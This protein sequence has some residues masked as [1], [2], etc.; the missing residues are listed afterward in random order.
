[1]FVILREADREKA[2]RYLLREPEM[3]LFF[4]GDLENHGFD[5]EDVTLH[6]VLKP[7]GS[8][9]ALA[10]RYQESWLV[11]SDHEDFD[12]RAVAELLREGGMK[13]MSGKSSV[14]R[15][16]A[17]FFP[18]YM[19][20]HM[21]MARLDRVRADCSVPQ[22]VTLRLLQK[23]DAP[24]QVEIICGIAEFDRSQETPEQSRARRL[25]ITL[26]DMA[27]GGVFIGAFA[28]GKLVS[29]ASTT[30]C[31]SLSA[32]VVGVATLAPWRGKGLASAAVCA[33]CRE[34]FAQGKQYL[35]L[36]YSNPAAGRIYHRLGF[37]DVGEYMML[38]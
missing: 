9:D 35:C 15:R 22:G 27:H 5:S 7:D 34:S 2:Y 6:A 37:E 31:N 16:I 4:Y 25:R 36:F 29:T 21:H 20:E 12:A 19:A 28:D 13:D 26:D 32:M 1:M 38:K 11:Y 8:W 17:P 18:E 3:N 14:I 33:V 23:E 24:A 10:L 30:A